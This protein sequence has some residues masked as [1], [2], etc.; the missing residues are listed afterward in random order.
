MNIIRQIQPKG[1]PIIIDAQ[2]DDEGN[3]LKETVRIFPILPTDPPLIG[4]GLPF[5]ISDQYKPT[6]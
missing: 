1:A 6:E 3:I 2:T 5:N 4:E